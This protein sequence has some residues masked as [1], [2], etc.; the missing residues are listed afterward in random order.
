MLRI[1][2]YPV[3]FGIVLAIFILVI[4]GFIKKT[5]ISDYLPWLKYIDEII[6]SFMLFFVLNFVLNKKNKIKSIRFFLYIFSL[7]WIVSFL[8]SFIGEV[9]VTQAIYQ[10]VLDLKYIIVFLYC[11]FAYRREETK[12]MIDSIFRILIYLNIPFV[13]MQMFFPDIYDFIFSNGSHK[14]VFIASG[15]EH[16]A[17]SAGIF[18]F[19]GELA[20]FSA[21]SSGFYLIYYKFNKSNGFLYL[22][23]MSFFLLAST[24]SRGEIA[25]F[26]LSFIL[27]NVLFFSDRRNLPVIFIF[28]VLILFVFMIYF[29]LEIISLL[30]EIGVLDAR[31][32]AS[33]RAK[34]MLSALEEGVD[35][36]PLGAGLGALGGQSAVV[37]DSE[38]FYK[39]GF[40]YE[41]YFEYGI[42]LTDTY[43]PKVI[44][45][46]GF[47]GTLLLFCAY[48]FFPF[49]IYTYLHRKKTELIAF[50]FFCS[51]ALLINSFSSPVY[52]SV[53]LVI[54]ASISIGSVIEDS[55]NE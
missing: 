52:N 37:F 36:F 11:M 30:Q 9:K 27:L 1:P 43:W 55:P 22:F 47:I 35:G 23:L 2:A 19:T 45:E 15:G 48:I 32:D 26:F 34:M 5:F 4:Q 21:I 49:Y 24:I 50:S 14:G 39:Y 44:A 46:S 10:F 29:N 13:F 31:L 12:R 42:Y 38:L 25:S 40:Q 3:P 51:F 54:F 18:W 28:S 7:Y 53:L 16:Y 20:F 41:W 17:R 33:P 8:S 6:V